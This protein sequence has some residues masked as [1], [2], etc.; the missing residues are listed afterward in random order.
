MQRVA[1][2]SVTTGKWT[3]VGIWQA[4][5]WPLAPSTMCTKEKMLKNKQASL[6]SGVLVWVRKKR[7]PFAFRIYLSHI[8]ISAAERTRPD[9]RATV[10]VEDERPEWTV[11]SHCACEAAWGEGEEETFDVFWLNIYCLFTPTLS[12][13]YSSL[14]KRQSNM[15]LAL[16]SDRKGVLQG[17]VVVPLLLPF[18]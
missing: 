13:F 6:C 1:L 8:R 11:W 9:R 2:C 15:T 10:Q 17:C 7:I 16:L 14:K 4:S 18:I 5:E 3:H 12:H